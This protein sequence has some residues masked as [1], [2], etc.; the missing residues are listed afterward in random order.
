M[1]RE[2]SLGNQRRFHLKRKGDEKRC[3][4]FEYFILFGCLI[5][6]VVVSSNRI[7]YD[8]YTI[9][10]LK[11][12]SYFSMENTSIKGGI[13]QKEKVFSVPET[14]SLNRFMFKE[15][16]NE[17][18][19]FTKTRSGS[20]NE[21]TE[22]PDRFIFK[23]DQHVKSTFTKTRSGSENEATKRPDSR[24]AYVT[25]IH[26]IDESY[27]YRG[28]LYNCIIVKENL[29]KVGSTADFIALVGFTDESK[30]KKSLFLN[31]LT[32]LENFGILIFYLPRLVPNV[33]KV[34]FAEMAL[35]KITPWSFL[36]YDRIQFF[37]GDVLPLENMDCFFNLN[38]NTF[39]TGTASPLNSGWF[40]AIP[41]IK[42]FAYMRE[43]AIVRL[44]TPWNELIGWN[45][46]MPK[47]VM[48][49]GWHKP[50]KKWEFNGASLDQGLIFH[51]FCLN[52]GSI[53][54]IDVRQAR[55]YSPGHSFK[56]SSINKAI[57]CCNGKPSTKYFAHFTGRNKPWLSEN[58]KS[59][60][61]EVKI[62]LD[63]LDS[64]ELAVNSTSLKSVSLKSPLGYFHPNKR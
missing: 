46:T 55:V 7:N 58:I 3:W 9:P 64:L 40:L 54:L 49:R 20:G 14:L 44:T 23:G 16:Q 32:L 63:L 4:Y 57:A 27:K 17:K 47:E 13:L 39:N 53:Q 56:L 6:L 36:Q 1:I 45:E 42:A 5:F 8:K 52:S 43:K 62:W 37:D 26:G 18:S 33:R 51:Y 31:D 28:F 25:L 30:D 48:Y 60:S 2:K 12:H 10:S 29:K 41:N 21:A 19:T 61:K 59:P 35:L 50:V 34:S 24:F 22:R 38:I 15:D 11:A